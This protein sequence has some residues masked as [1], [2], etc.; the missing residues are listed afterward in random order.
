VNI[1][2]V[3]HDGASYHFNYIDKYELKSNKIRINLILNA[4]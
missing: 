2:P 1:V 4:A 3:A